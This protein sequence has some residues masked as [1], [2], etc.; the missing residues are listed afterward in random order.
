MTDAPSP[1]AAGESVKNPEARIT[2]L[3]MR[4]LDGGLRDLSARE[5]RVIAA[6]AKRHHV[7]RSLNNTIDDG[8]TFGD[9]I[10]DRVARFGGSWTFII[11]FVLGLAAWVVGNTL[12]LARAG[13]AFDPYPFIFLNLIL[14]MVAALQAPII[15]MSQNRQAARDRISAALD[16]EVNLKAELEIMALHEKLDALRIDRLEALLTSQAEVLDLLV[17]RRPGPV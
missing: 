3:A 9:H 4:L 8:E 16:Y 11:I 12:L 6:I 13:P 14:S 2:A 1:P 5:Q 17:Q 15:L 7:T 10:A